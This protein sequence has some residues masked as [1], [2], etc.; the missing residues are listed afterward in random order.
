VVVVVVIID[1]V[2]VS[3]FVEFIFHF[4]HLY[5][6]IGQDLAKICV[7]DALNHLKFGQFDMWRQKLGFSEWNEETYNNLLT[8]LDLMSSCL[9]DYTIFWRELAHISDSLVRDNS[10]S[11]VEKHFSERLM[12]AFYADPILKPDEAELKERWLEWLIRWS[13]LMQS[14]SVTNVWKFYSFLLPSF[15]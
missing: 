13:S 7:A 2:D 9:V 6:F 8:V 10:S 1:D 11:N 4:R 15:L 12:R 14:Q 5:S 3:I